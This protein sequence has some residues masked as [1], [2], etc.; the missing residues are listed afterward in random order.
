MIWFLVDAALLPA[1]LL[2]IGALLVAIFVLE[3]RRARAEAD[4]QATLQR[5]RRMANRM[6]NVELARGNQGRA[7]WWAKTLRELH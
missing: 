5:H 3:A 7:E 2:L 1:V 4:R 6:Y